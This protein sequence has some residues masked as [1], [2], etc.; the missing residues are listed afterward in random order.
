MIP[1]ALWYSKGLGYYIINIHVNVICINWKNGS[2]PR[3][4]SIAIWSHKCTKVVKLK[5]S[6]SATRN[7]FTLFWKSIAFNAHSKSQNRTFQL[8]IEVCKA[9]TPSVN[10]CILPISS[11]LLCIWHTNIQMWHKLESYNWRY[12]SNNEKPIKKNHW[13]AR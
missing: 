9:P 3:L 4:S 11:R 12:H 7:V 13:N 8:S 2:N 10:H 6:S 1:Y 5:I